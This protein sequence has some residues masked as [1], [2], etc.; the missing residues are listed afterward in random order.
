MLQRTRGLKQT[1]V[2]SLLVSCTFLSIQS[3]AL[4]LGEID[5]QSALNE[6]FAG[7]IELLDARGLQSGEVVV[8]MASR[9]DFERIGVERFFFLTDLKFD[10]VLDSAGAVS[11][12]VTS[13][14]PVSEPYLNFIVEV[15][16]PNG[17]LLKEFTV[18][19]DPPTFSE[20]SAPIVESP[21]QTAPAAR[22]ATQSQ[23]TAPVER[24]SSQIS[25]SP[26]SAPS[27]SDGP[28]QGRVDDALMT[29]RDD[30]LWKI[31]RRT[32]ETRRVSVNQ[33]M[34][35]IQRMNPRAFIRNNINLLKAG[36]RLDLPSEAEALSLASLEANTLVEDQS[37]AWRSGST[38]LADR[39]PATVL[40][41]DPDSAAQ[42]LSSQVDATAPKQTTTRAGDDGQGQVR[43]VANSGELAKGS[44]SGDEVNQ[45]IED[46]AS[47]NRQIED[48]NYEFEQEKQI[49]TNQISVKDRQLEVKN[50]ELAQLQ[51]QL[52][53][54]RS[55]M[56]KIAENQNQRTNRQ[57]QVTEVWWQT[58]LVLF[59]IIGI[60][61]VFLAVLLVVMRRRRAEQAAME[62]Y[63]ADEEAHDDEFDEDGA[64]E[65]E[66]DAELAVVADQDRGED[67]ENDEADEEI[68]PS[69][70]TS[71]S[72]RAHDW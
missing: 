49:A 44:G 54:M 53:V 25:L 46:K 67:G 66:F 6:R 29:T 57:P 37:L 11:V 50:Q 2:L 41:D 60:L 39:A 30:T 5:V 71:G 12:E 43:I 64:D 68:E 59:S 56:K 28:A 9:E 34:L 20:A 45:L 14:Q 36:Y 23:P 47:L 21:L 61:I 65:D 70:R 33:Q 24:P 7:S 38:T 15:L 62:E 22:V 55:E 51:E 27:A 58:P 31:A 18:L 4:G 3:W 52:T 35:A 63:L 72:D 69:R 42:T 10:V 1:L 48:L 8:K 19:L 13:R 26:S 16:W 17:R 40:I 32:R